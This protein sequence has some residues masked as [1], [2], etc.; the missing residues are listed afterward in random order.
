MFH[1][2]LTSWLTILSYFPP[3]SF[4]KHN[5]PTSFLMRLAWSSL[6]VPKLQ[7]CGAAKIGLL[8]SVAV[9]IFEYSSLEK[10]PKACLSNYQGR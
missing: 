9:L 8:F 10:E 6:L 7:E 3:H 4:Y 2:A 5:I 1:R